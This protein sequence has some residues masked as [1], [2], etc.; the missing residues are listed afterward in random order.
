MRPV[1]LRALPRRQDLAARPRARSGRRSSSRCRGCSRRCSTA[2]A[3]APTRRA[4]SKGRI[5]DAAAQT[6]IAYSKALDA[7][8]AGLG[9]RVKHALFD[10]LVY[11]KLRAVFGGRLTY[12]ISGGAPLGDRL[13]HFY[14]GQGLIIFEGYGLTETTAAMCVNSTVGDPARHRRPS[15]AWRLGEDRRRQRDPRPRGRTSSSATG[16]TRPRRARPSTM[17]AGSPPATSVS[18]TVTVTSG[19][20][21][22]RRN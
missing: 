3:S 4:R 18:S 7:G 17:T 2:P 13:S 14:R 11:S 22:A 16:R 20:P 10:R 12:A 21:G 9:L 1:T 5:F 15:A 8:G 19:S 6:A